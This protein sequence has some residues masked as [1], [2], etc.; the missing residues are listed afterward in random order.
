MPAA[1]P[2]I[3]LIASG[4]SAGVGL[5]Q[6]HKANQQQQPLMQSATDLAKQ[7]A[8]QG[9]QLFNFG[10][11]LLERS[12]G[13][14]GSLL[15]G[16][17]ASVQR[18]LAPTIAQMTDVYT[19][20]ERNLSRMTPGAGRDEAIANLNKQRAGAIGGL[21]FQAR[22]GAADALTNIGSSA[23]GGGVNATGSAGG[24][25]GGLLGQQ[26]ALDK[27]SSEQ[28]YQMGQNLSSLISQ[29]IQAYRARNQG[30]AAYANTP[31]GRV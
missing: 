17:R 27:F 30:Q 16:N 4:V 23:T 10:M 11:P 15:S 8:G 31:I 13:Y 20:A 25:Y 1:I 21:P 9:R 22:Q 19:G 2:F 14:Y 12:A 7:Q 18:T 24:L 6:Q 5:Y 28:Q 3:P 26:L 29:F